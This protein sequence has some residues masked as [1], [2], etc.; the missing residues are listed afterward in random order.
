MVNEQELITLL[1]AHRWTLQS[2]TMAGGKKAYTAK[3]RQ[4][5][6]MATRYIG[7]EN[8]L[9]DMTEEEILEKLNK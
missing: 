1:K 6:K 4:A 7:T 9:K 8:R 2:S 5:G 3:Q